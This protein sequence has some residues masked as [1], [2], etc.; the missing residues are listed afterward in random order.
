MTTLLAGGPP[1]AVSCDAHL[2]RGIVR[3]W[4][5]DLDGAVAD[6]AAA[7][8]SAAGHDG[9]PGDAEG[10]HPGSA[11]LLARADVGSYQA[12][13][14][15]RAGRWPEA[16]DLA[17]AIASVV[18]DAGDAMVVALPHAEA[19]FVLAGM[20]RVDDA[21]AHL[22]AAVASAEATGLMPPRLWAAHATLRVAAARADHVRVA[23][24]GDALVAEGLATLPEGIHHW[25]A[26]YVEALLALGRLDDARRTADELGRLAESGT[27][28]SL[29]ADAARAAGAVAAAD[30]R[31][32]EAARMFAAGLELDP[33]AS[34]PFERARLELAAGAHLR[35]SGHRREAAAVLTEAARRLDAM[36]A[37]PWAKR[38]ARELDA[39]GLR[40]R[41]RTPG[42]PLA[43]DAALTAQERLVA[44]LVAGG[45]T[46]R[47]VAAELVI[48]TKTVEHHLGRIY[49]KLGL[50]SR[51]EL[52]ARLA[53]GTNGTSG[54]RSGLAAGRR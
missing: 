53:V 10:L 13:V 21:Q 8:G 22:D 47:E 18:D 2:G 34:R 35:R 41:R 29:A 23:D 25:R 1:P 12:E 51:S 31:A 52:A 45:R 11:S 5:N 15:Y 49:A 24:V 16:L 30:G 38:C 50:R 39:C 19:T 33:V 3:V 44:H 7:D 32:E 17:E 36:G 43:G 42:A 26:T 48:T 37:A 46:N 54:A 28:V 40:P 14:A 20:G 4:S 6:L 27:D 9:P